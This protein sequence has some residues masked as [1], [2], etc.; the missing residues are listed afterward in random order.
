MKNILIVAGEA[1][2]DNLGARLI[3]ELR[4]LRSDVQ[5]FGLGGDKMAAEGVNLI[6]HIRQ[7]AFLGFWEAVKNYH[8]IKNIQNNLLRQISLLKPEMAILIDYPGFNLRLARRLRQ[9]GIK[10]FYYVSPQIWAWGANRIGKIKRDVDLMA[11]FFDFEKKLYEKAGIPVVWVGHPLIDEINIRLTRTEFRQKL[12]V[13]D[14]EIVIGLFP[15]SRELEVKRLLP[16]LLKATIIMKNRYPEIRAYV[17]KADALSES[18]Y[19]E[20]F[21]AAGVSIPFYKGDNHELMAFSR[22]CLVCSGTATLECAIIG[23]PL[24]VLYK[25]S[26]IT[27]LIARRLISI[28]Q[29]GLVNIVAGKMIVPELIQGECNG[30]KI[31]DNALNLIENMGE[32]DRVKD[33]LSKIKTRLGEPGAAQKAAYAAAGLLGT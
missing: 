15:G 1:S 31:A 19:R 13:A 28:G 8:H 33:E 30:L 11:V 10:V 29:I 23:T 21:L 17:A 2:G 9:Q 20:I 6:Y 25:T 27:Y 32:Y 5:F 22:L 4:Q 7:L 3:K 12:N 14:N 18:L 24:L 16:E 26:Y